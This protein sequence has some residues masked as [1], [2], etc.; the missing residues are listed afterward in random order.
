MSYQTYKNQI[1]YRIFLVETKKYIK[2]PTLVGYFLIPILLYSLIFFLKD[3]A[4]ALSFTIFTQ[5]LFISLFVYGNKIKDYHNDTMMKKINNSDV[6]LL[7]I[8]IVQ[9]LLANAILFISLTV[10]LVYSVISIDSLSYFTQNQYAFYDTLGEDQTLSIM[11]QGLPI[12]LLLFNSNSETRLQFLFAL[13]FVDLAIF[14]IA[15]LITTFIKKTSLYFTTVLSLFV[16]IILF[17]SLLNKQIFILSDEQYTRD[18]TAIQNKF[19][20]FLKYLNPFY[21]MNQILMNTIIADMYS[22][23]FEAGEVPDGVV[24]FGTFYP[25][26]FDIFHIGTDFSNLDNANIDYEQIGRPIFLES[27]EIFQILILITPVISFVTTTSISL[28]KGMVI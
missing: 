7:Q 18:I 25:S 6:S 26:Y 22:G 23:H 15:H 14:S 5:I 17:S 3:G 27:I 13:V 16:I 21:W 8:T 10:P 4:Y 24:S 11:N 2:S 12:D 1:M 28:V 20:L 19:F 9:F